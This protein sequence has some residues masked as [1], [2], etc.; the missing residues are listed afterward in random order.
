MNCK[1]PFVVFAA[2][3]VLVA[4]MMTRASVFTGSADLALGKE[5]E[6]DVVTGP[7]QL[8]IYPGDAFSFQITLTNFG[9]DL[10]TNI[11]VQD[12]LPPGLNY[13]SSFGD[14]FY[15]VLNNRWL[16]DFA[17]PGLIYHQTVTVY[18]DT[19]GSFTNVVL[20]TSSSVMD[21]NFSNDFAFAVANVGPG[22]PSADLAIKLE[23]STNV[24]R[25]GDIFTLDVTVTNIGPNNA[26]NIFVRLPVPTNALFLTQ[27]G[28]SKW[29]YDPTTGVATRPDTL[30]KGV[31]TTF[32]L[33]FQATN[34]GVI[35]FT[36]QITN[37][38]P[39]DP[40]PGNNSA[41]TNI[42]VFSVF[43]LSGVVVTCST[44]GPPLT[45]VR[46]VINATNQPAQSTIT[47]TN[48]T[49]VFTNLVPATY[50][51]FIATNIY[52]FSPSNQIVVLASNT[53]LP[54]FVGS[55]RF[56]SGTVRQGTNGS[57]L[58]N[59]TVKITGAASL[60]S[61]TDTNGS[62]IFTNLNAGTYIIAP[63][64]NGLPGIRFTP[65]SI[66]NVLGSPTNCTATADFITTNLIIV[67]RALEVVQ[68]VQDWSNSV[69]LVAKKATL[70]RAH[71]Q[72]F[73]TNTQ[74]VLIENA[75][76]FAQNTTAATSAD[77][78][79]DNGRITVRT[80]DCTS[81]V[82]RSNINATL[83]FTV[84]DGWKTGQDT[85]R[86]TWTNGVV[87]NAEPRDVAGDPASNGMV[88]VSFTP[89]PP[90]GVRFIRVAF[91]NRVAVGT[92]FVLVTN[93]PTPAQID[94]QKRRVISIYPIVEIT[95][96]PYGFFLW[97]RAMGAPTNELRLLQGINASR[98]TS[99][100]TNGPGTNRIWYGVVSQNLILRGLGYQ[101]GFAAEGNI[102]AADQ[103][104]QRHLAAHEIG[105][106]LGRPHSVHSTFGAGACGAGKK[107]GHCNECAAGGT[108]DF[109]M[110]ASAT[111]GLM[112]TLGPLTGADGVIWGYDH[113]L[114]QVVSPYFYYDLMSY[115]AAH[116]APIPA[117]TGS[118][119]WIAKHT[120]TNLFTAISSRFGPAP[121]PIHEGEPVPGLIQD[122]LL[123]RGEIDLDSNNVEFQPCYPIQH[124]LPVTP[125]SYML[126]LLDTNGFSLLD[127]PFEPEV[128]E[129]EFDNEPNVGT[130]NLAVPI[131]P[132]AVGIQILAGGNPIGQLLADAYGPTVKILQPNGGEIFGNTNITVSWMASD[133][134]NSPLSYLVQFS[135][136]GGISWDTIGI[137]LDETNLDIPPDT[138]PATTN[139]LIRV[140]ASDSL[141][142]FTAQSA[143]FFTVNPHAPIIS[144]RQPAEGSL[145]FGDQT[146]VF[147]ASASDLEDGPLDG[148]NVVWISNLDGRLGNGSVLPL[149]SGSLS[150]GVH[151]IT[152][153]AFANSGLT[154]SAS[155]QIT[156][157]RLEPP[158]LSI[159]LMG[160]MAQLSWPARY[161]NYVLEAA[162][163]LA[164]ANWMTVG[165]SPVVVDDQ[166]TV[167]VNIETA[168]FFR[169]RMQ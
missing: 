133:P 155:V 106:T 110:Y 24:L 31:D 93:I 50:T 74:P 165:I 62:Y 94:E 169:L 162:A 134:D 150:E 103:D 159:Q 56:I 41:N 70:V 81:P 125:G 17:L 86:F 20:I 101:P 139:G 35:A 88:R 148:T 34:G 96:L 140:I 141:H 164:P 21:T 87:F 10:A 121:A 25:I 144:I 8:S 51:V 113:Y 55:A 13:V 38:Q 14:G 16:L 48:G 6:A 149:E 111:Q 154:A 124:A 75:R 59:V 68:V 63:Q 117:D 167:T 73:G 15:D 137:D 92:N 89:M 120:Y 130:F 91:T 72:L 4:P 99:S 57:P 67:L 104:F 147:E 90:L 118:W 37:S 26:S 61:L 23:P 47:S 9:P 64:T 132:D 80:N 3:L 77:W 114:N 129:G 54:P 122:Y 102:S 152:A 29:I 5:L 49:F 126:R 27:V 84:R 82:L 78:S 95:N 161:T 71:L 2:I 115:C 163:S 108:P 69:P 83:N 1:I 43:S 97:T 65:G 112:P 19:N 135:R 160:D 158:Q 30:F 142:T 151:F 11:I 138:L 105:H 98:L 168:K 53:N 128:P 7:N 166:Q 28:F 145:Y 123:V 42:P 119:T 156:V 143:G 60:T 131:L 58:P 79:P 116:N 40:V 52:S 18:A 66:T 36:A 157:L 44:N 33:R 136:D 107:S 46:V 76:L 39:T 146:I 153:T 32:T 12:Y 22:S 127:I 85:F 100:D 45:G 109:P